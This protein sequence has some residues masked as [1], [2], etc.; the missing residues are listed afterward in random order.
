M[1]PLGIPDARTLLSIWVSIVGSSQSPRLAATIV[2]LVVGSM[3]SRRGHITQALLSIVPGRGWQAYFWALERGGFR[4]L[5]L[6]RAVCAVAAD[7]HPGGRLFFA[8]DDTF[9][10]RASKKAPDSV[11]THMHTR[12]PNQPEFMLG[13]TVVCLGLV[14][15]SSD[16]TVERAV[17]LAAGF[18]LKPEHHG[19]LGRAAALLRCVA[20]CFQGAKTLLMDSWYMKAHLVSAAMRLGFDVV[21]NVR[22]DTALYAPAPPRSGRRG[23]PKVKGDRIE[24]ASLPRVTPKQTFSFYGGKRIRFRTAVC[25]AGFLELRKVRAVWLELADPKTPDRWSKPRLLLSTDPSLDPISVVLAYAKRWSVEDLFS[26]LKQGEGMKDLWMRTRRTYLRWLHVLFA[27]CA[28]VQLLALRCGP[29]LLSGLPNMGWRRGLRA[30]AGMA[31]SVL[32]SIFGD[33][34]IRRRWDGRRRKFDL[35]RAEIAPVL[36]RAG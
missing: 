22:R 28:L 18:G 15:P 27:G 30:T 12:K 23:R 24:E 3:L 9:I 19:K 25:L 14:V 8:L 20:G 2:E 13:Q 17:P 35:F 29:E 5:S 11:V 6:I 34:R 26:V 10:P 31:K 21:G 4:L 1:I 36:V 32:P 16:G 7:A 33:L